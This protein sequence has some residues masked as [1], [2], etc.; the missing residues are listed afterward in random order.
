MF[1][2]GMRLQQLRKASSMSQ[3]ALGKRI[4]RSKSVICAYESN[5]RV[6]PLEILAKIAVV[7]NVSVDYLVGLDKMEM[8]SIEELD[9]K[10]KEIIHALIYEFKNDDDNT[11]GL[12][13]FQQSILNK[14][15]IEFSKKKKQ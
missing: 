10:Q 11:S 1:D 14:I 7:F 6:P 15:I 5:L 8:V 4:G 12:S 9:D 13:N 2:F 3:E